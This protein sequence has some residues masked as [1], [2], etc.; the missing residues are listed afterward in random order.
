MNKLKINILCILTLIS[1]FSFIKNTNNEIEIAGIIVSSNNFETIKDAKIYDTNNIL[2]ASTDS[3][4]YFKTKIKYDI[5]KENIQFSFKVKKDGY[6][7]LIQNEKWGIN[8]NHKGIFYIGLSKK[9]NKIIRSFSK[10]IDTNDTNYKNIKD[11]SNNL[12]HKILFEKKLDSLKEGNQFVYF[13]L[14]SKRFIVNDYGWIELD[15]NKNYIILDESSK[16]II[17]DSINSILKRNKIT[18]MTP[19]KNNEDF[20]KINTK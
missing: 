19:S 16:K 2:I 8:N 4:G 3:N 18:S 20:I 9:H 5:N 6:S 1:L 15:S 12:N 10:L 17:V 13:K 14:D 11:L 7:N